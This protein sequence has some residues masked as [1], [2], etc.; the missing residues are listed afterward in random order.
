MNLSTDPGGDVPGL[1][2]IGVLYD[3]ATGIAAEALP[4]LRAALEADRPVSAVVEPDEAKSLRRA[5]PRDTALI[6]AAPARVVDTGTGLLEHLRGL[7][8]DGQALVL[9]QCSM[10]QIGDIALRHSEDQINEQLAELPVTLICAYSTRDRFPRLITARATHPYLTY[11]GVPRSN[12]AYRA[13]G[14]ALEVDRGDHVLG[15][16]FRGRPELHHVRAQV[17]AAAATAGLTAAHIDAWVTAVHEA[18]VIVSEAAAPD[19]VESCE[20]DMWAAQSTVSAEVRGPTTPGGPPDPG[21]SPLPGPQDSAPDPLVGVKLFCH[22]VTE[23]VDGDSRIVRLL[24]R[25]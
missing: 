8:G 5:L 11:Q 21:Q 17:R 25:R 18:A 23:L 7:G 6:I 12:S 16:T 22:E 13:P 15:L 3:P 20:L 24:S 14:A 2:H 9:A 1:E 4:L 10:F 19:D